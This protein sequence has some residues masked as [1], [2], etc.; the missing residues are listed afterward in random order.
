MY[1]IKNLEWKCLCY[2]TPYYW[3]REDKPQWRVTKEEAIKII[4]EFDNCTTDAI[5]ADT[6]YEVVE[7][8]ASPTEEDMRR[9]RDEHYCTN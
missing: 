7:V 3:S 2:W 9:Q 8:I 1:I 5:T 6:F 4:T